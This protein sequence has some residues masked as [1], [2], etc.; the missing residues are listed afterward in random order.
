MERKIYIPIWNY[1]SIVSAAVY[2]FRGC[3][4]IWIVLYFLVEVRWTGKSEVSERGLG[5]ERMKG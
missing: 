2:G 1:T 4:C 3:C 5:L